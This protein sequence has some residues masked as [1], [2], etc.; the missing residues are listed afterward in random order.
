MT[1]RPHWFDAALG[2]IC[3]GGGF[4]IVAALVFVGIPEGNRDAVVFAAGLVIGW[5]STVVNNRFGSSKGSDRKTE[6]LLAGPTDVRVTN[7]PGRSR[8]HGGCA[9]IPILRRLA[10]TPAS[11]VVPGLMFA[12][13]AGLA[14]FA[15]V[16]TSRLTSRTV[17]RDA[18]TAER[19]Q[20]LD[21]VTELTVPADK[22]GTRVRL[23]TPDALA[24]A[25]GLGREVVTRRAQ[26]RETTRRTQEA[27]VRSDAADVALVDVQRA[28]VRR[29]EPIKAT[30]Q[31]LRRAGPAGSAQGA[32]D[33]ID[34][35]SLLPW[36]GTGQ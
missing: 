29:S 3:V 23:S 13:F 36:Q 18:V 2:F 15:V 12:L 4:A 16:Q 22:T 10:S 14:V 7:S 9:M 25:R 6:A 27:V 30:A 34:A 35:A 32:A 20:V 26:D 8:A 24:A 21:V 31:R 17:E 11:L 28:N 5:G 1:D 19:D 33:A